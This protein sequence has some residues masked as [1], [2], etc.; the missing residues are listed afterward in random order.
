MGFPPT[1]VLCEKLRPV[2]RKRVG[3]MCGEPLC[4]GFTA[5]RTIFDH[6]VGRRERRHDAAAVNARVGVGEQKTRRK[7]NA[8]I[9]VNN[10]LKTA[11]QADTMNRAMNSRPVRPNHRRSQNAKGHQASGQQL[12]FAQLLL[13]LPGQCDASV[14][15]RSTFPR[16]NPEQLPRVFGRDAPDFLTA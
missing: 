15:A 16:S 6:S 4:F 10:R 3:R 14:P 12:L 1:L 7:R 13:S 8:H 2:G 5:L 9:A 11:S